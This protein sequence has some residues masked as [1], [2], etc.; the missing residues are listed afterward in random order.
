MAAQSRGKFDR[1]FRRRPAHR[2]SPGAR[3]PNK[4]TSP[5]GCH[6]R[7]RIWAP[8]LDGAA[9]KTRFRAGQKG[10]DRPRGNPRFT[11]TEFYDRYSRCLPADVSH[12][13]RSSRRWRRFRGT[14]VT[15][16]RTDANRRE[17]GKWEHWPDNGRSQYSPEDWEIGTK[18]W[19]RSKKS[20]AELP[21]NTIASRTHRP[22]SPNSHNLKRAPNQMRPRWS[23]PLLNLSS[24]K[25]PRRRP[26]SL[27]RT[28]QPLRPRPPTHPPRN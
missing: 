24:Q 7:R 23:P 14:I 6:G 12:P 17:R 16:Y 2:I 27:S 18:K 25:S 21:N 10:V 5:F 11:T 26:Q 4:S 19:K 22:I 20:H 15:R 3:F 9:R 28:K 8:H 13:E 1:H